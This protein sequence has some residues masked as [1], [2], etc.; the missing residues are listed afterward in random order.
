M[1]VYRHI[2]VISPTAEKIPPYF[3]FIASA[4]KIPPKSTAKRVPTTLDTAQK[5]PSTNEYRPKGTADTGYRPKL[6]P[7]RYRVRWIPP[8][9]CRLH[10]RQLLASC[11]RV[12]IALVGEAGRS[13]YSLAHWEKKWEGAFG[14][15]WGY[16]RRFIVN[17]SSH[18][19]IIVVSGYCFF[20]FFVRAFCMR[21]LNSIH[22]E[23]GNR[24]LSCWFCLD[25]SLVI[26]VQTNR[27]KVMYKCNLRKEVCLS[28]IHI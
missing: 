17:I 27:S 26:A 1:A 5:V 12:L 24:S 13:R 25:F 19:I 14:R 4:K 23:K 9:R 10:N 3:G 15:G 2:L 20:S 16:P 8:K 28:L 6:P 18:S 21:L 11:R 22:D 7:K